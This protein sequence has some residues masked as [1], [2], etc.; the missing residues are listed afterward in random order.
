M[1]AQIVTATV[2]QIM[3]HIEW[4]SEAD[5]VI[6]KAQQNA[7]N[8]ALVY[9]V[10]DAYK[11]TDILGLCWLVNVTRKKGNKSETYRSESAILIDHAA[12]IV[13]DINAAVAKEIQEIDSNE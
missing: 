10:R 4:T 2:E 1:S 12:K 13:N 5:E 9:N 8:L 11:Y 7:H 6:K 3:D